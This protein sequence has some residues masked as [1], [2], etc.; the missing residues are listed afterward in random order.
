[1]HFE[2]IKSNR[3]AKSCSISKKLCFYFNA[4]QIL[5]LLKLPEQFS[6]VEPLRSL[7]L[8][9]FPATSKG[10]TGGRVPREPNALTGFKLNQPKHF[11]I[12][13]EAHKS[14]TEVK[15]LLTC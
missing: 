3:L 7:L 4:D 10:A 5:P 12:N 1:M 9:S 11:N 6:E 2:T 15:R 14:T 8:T 13:P